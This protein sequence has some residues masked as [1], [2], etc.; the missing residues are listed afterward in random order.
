MLLS[1][2]AY[3]EVMD[4]E[5]SLFQ[6]YLW[7][8]LGVL[9]CFLAARFK[10]LF[11]LLAAPLPILYFSA[12]IY[13][14]LDPYVGKDILHEAGYFYVISSYL[15]A[16]AIFASIGTGLWLRKNATT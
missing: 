16:I 2:P 10:P 11:L 5:P 15:L 9:I 3:A 14:I 4:K 6:N 12:L 13:E 8:I 7:G 1:N